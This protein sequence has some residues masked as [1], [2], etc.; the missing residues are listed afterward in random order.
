MVAYSFHKRFAPSVEALVKRQTIRA[1]G[2]RRHARPEEWLQLYFG[3]RTQYCRKLVTPDPICESVE[4]IRIWVPTK[5][6]P[7]AVIQKG[8]RSYVTD[9][10]AV[11]DGF[12]GVEDFTRFWFD[13]HGP[14]DFYGFLITWNP[15]IR[16]DWEAV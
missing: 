10:F 15:E 13:T 12:D 7:C 3:Q 6:E 11:A 16:R 1:D 14:G 5:F 9:E 8:K 2:K 4:P